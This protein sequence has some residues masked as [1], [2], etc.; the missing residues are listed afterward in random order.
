MCRENKLIRPRHVVRFHYVRVSPLPPLLVLGIIHPLP[1]GLS[2]L[3][4]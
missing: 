4:W 3:K 1:I 2:I